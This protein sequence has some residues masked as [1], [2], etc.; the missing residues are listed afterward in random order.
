MDMSNINDI[1]MVKTVCDAKLPPNNFLIQAAP[2]L[3]EY[4][5]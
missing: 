2:M 5:G 1:L 3:F 4:V